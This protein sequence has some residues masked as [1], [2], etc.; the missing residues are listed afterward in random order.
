MPPQCPPYRNNVSEYKMCC[1]S[2]T[3]CS[4]SHLYNTVFLSVAVTASEATAAWRV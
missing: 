2:N 4:R 3:G 1:I